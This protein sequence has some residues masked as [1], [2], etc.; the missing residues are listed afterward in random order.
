MIKVGRKPMI[1]YVIE[2]LDRSINIDKIMI[3]TSTHT[4]KTTEF[5]CEMGCDVVQTPGNGYVEDLQYLYLTEFLN[6]SNETILTITSDMPLIKSET[7]D[8]VLMIWKIE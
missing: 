5:V 7:I 2:A 4:P 3:L 8:Q 6:N 1:Q